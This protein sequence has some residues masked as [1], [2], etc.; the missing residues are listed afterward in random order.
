MLVEGGVRVPGIPAK[1]PTPEKIIRFI[2]L[3]V[4][5][6]GL[7]AD[8]F[9]NGMPNNA[10]P[11]MFALAVLSA[12]PPVSSNKELLDSV[13]ACTKK[14]LAS[15]LP[16]TYTYN[17]IFTEYE[18]YLR[19]F[20]KSAALPKEAVMSNPYEEMAKA[21][22]YQMGFGEDGTRIFHLTM[23]VTNYCKDAIAMFFADT[24]DGM[25]SPKRKIPNS[26]EAYSFV[27]KH[28]NNTITDDTFFGGPVPPNATETFTA[29]YAVVALVAPLREN[30]LLFDTLDYIRFLLTENKYSPLF[31]D[32]IVQEVER[33]LDIYK[34]QKDEE[35]ALLSNIAME[36]MADEACR[37]MGLYPDA[38]L[39][40]NIVAYFSV[41]FFDAMEELY[42]E[43]L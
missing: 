33:L 5:D 18:R 19:V 40:F 42:P 16:I 25:S 22:S 24:A 43:V 36:M 37:T 12:I 38:L 6:A 15:D 2:N 23:W 7:D 32:R 13:F 41:L 8:I 9:P 1:F 20:Q 4:T 17:D 35:K 39:K 28:V 27:A 31:F 10:T 34:A 30:R 21:A 14:E 26:V 29:L 3:Q 11:T